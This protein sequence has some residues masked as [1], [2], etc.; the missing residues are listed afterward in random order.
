MTLEQAE[1]VGVKAAAW[2]A[3]KLWFAH[4]LADH[5]GRFVSPLIDYFYERCRDATPEIP[6]AGLVLTKRAGAVRDQLG[7]PRYTDVAAVPLLRT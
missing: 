6:A 1:L 5:Y 2:W 7:A 4:P 3:I